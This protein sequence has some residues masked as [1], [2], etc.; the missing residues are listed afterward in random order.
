[1]KIPAALLDQLSAQRRAGRRVGLVVRHAE[2]HPITDLQDHHTLLLT[3][4]GHAMA[5][6]SGQA[7]ARH[8]LPAGRLRAVHS[9]VERCA[10]TAR[11]LVQGARSA[12]AEAV[13]VGADT[14]LGDPFL[15]D[16]RRALAHA[17]D[18]GH[19][20]LRAWFSGA[21]PEGML[22]DHRAAARD[23]LA[24]VQRHLMSST[25]DDVVVFVSHDWNIAIVREVALQFAYELSWPGFLDGVVVA[26]DEDDVL[27]AF[28]NRTGRVV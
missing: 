20:F 6:E 22:Q 8:V 18:L 15:L 24:A 3:S 4:H 16:R 14:V 12:G 11:G 21:A 19:Q 1:M 2:R 28:D 17:Q 25:P 13:V 27:V 5:D 23:Q 9:P 7:L 10:Q 26:L